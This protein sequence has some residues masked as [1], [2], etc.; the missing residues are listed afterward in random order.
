M[1]AASAPV[2][3]VSPVLGVSHPL[4]TT[5]RPIWQKLL[6]VF[7]GAGGFLAESKPYLIAHPREYLDHS[8]PE[9]A[10][11]G[12]TV[13]GYSL[14]LSPSSP[15]PK[16]LERRKLA[17]YE[18]IAET[19][20]GQL[21]AA[22]FRVSP[23]RTF[24]EASP[25][26][27]IG[28]RPIEQFHDDADGLGTKWDELLR[29]AWCPAAVFGHVFI[30]LDDAPEDDARTVPV[31]RLY[32]PL[33]VPDWLMNERGRL[34]QIKF[35]EAG[36]RES[37]KTPVTNAARNVRVRVV[38][39]EGWSIQTPGGQ[40]ID[41]G[42][43]SFG[44]LPVVVLYAKRR[45]ITPFIGKSVLGDP[46]NFIDLYNLVSEVRELL[47]KQT[48]SILN[49]PVGVDGSIDR[50]QG[51]IGRQSGTGNILFTTQAANYISAEGSNVEVYHAHIDRLIRTIYRL[52]VLPW[53]S[54]SRDAESS[55]SRRI[56]REDLNQ[57]LAGF[58]DELRRVDDA[59]ADLVYHAVYGP[60]AWQSWRKRDGLNQRWPDSFEVTPL[61]E[62]LKQFT[63]AIRLELGETATKEAKKRAVRAALPDLTPEMLAVI[64]DEVDKSEVVTEA[65]RRQ[66]QMDA[67]I[68]R[69]AGGARG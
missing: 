46:M 66:Q 3:T 39:D 28:K 53:E 25:A 55:D 38:T 10:D 65:E 23:V 61:E 16:L 41:A 22:L 62:L 20:V 63:D 69:F 7:E 34:T 58:S 19:L 4:Y 42:V 67:S 31:A 6:D 21:R 13:T 30:Y 17:R 37:F 29:Q 1:S 45:A 60:Q 26:P 15:S 36:P 40:V 52:A 9:Y 47:R 24:S 59:V 49:V 32:T 64:D 44:R 33:D 5:Y 27:A 8:I 18:N 14:N 54:D 48:F 51:L 68:Q 57:V 50:E 2:G 56:K 35:L 43:H 11:D 12:Q